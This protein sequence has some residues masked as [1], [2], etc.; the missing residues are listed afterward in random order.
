MADANERTRA[1]VCIQPVCVI[2]SV[3]NL[4]LTGNTLG[5]TSNLNRANL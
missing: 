2:K 4:A 3:E 1:T 5:S